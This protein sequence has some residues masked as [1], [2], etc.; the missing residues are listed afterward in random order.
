MLSFETGRRIFVA[1][2]ATDMRKSFNTLAA[3]VEHQLGHDPY[4]GDVFVFV[5][6]HRNRMKV[7]VWD[8]SG[9]WLC[10]KRLE[11]GT[12]AV[13]KPLLDAGAKDTVQVSP[14][15]M[16]LVLEGISVHRATY[17]RHYHRPD[18]ARVPGVAQT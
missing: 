10:A 2:A 12:F 7:L 1:R 4:A 5:G 11:Q 8:A 16:A 14:A 18:N 13:P 15:E 3:L 9:F 6:R 17:H